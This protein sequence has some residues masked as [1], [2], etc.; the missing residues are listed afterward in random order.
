MVE[1]FS[2][3]IDLL[4]VVLAVATIYFRKLIGGKVGSS[5]QYLTLGLILLG[6]SSLV[7]TIVVWFDPTHPLIPLAQRIMMLVGF[8]FLLWGNWRLARFLRT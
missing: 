3:L 2:L 1:A 8:S 7:D 5:T 4:L 6:V